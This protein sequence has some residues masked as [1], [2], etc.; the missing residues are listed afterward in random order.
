[1]QNDWRDDRRDDYIIQNLTTSLCGLKGVID[2]AP[3]RIDL[4]VQFL[5]IVSQFRRNTEPFLKRTA[6]YQYLYR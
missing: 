2:P 3:D 4:P 6:V 5:I 1:M